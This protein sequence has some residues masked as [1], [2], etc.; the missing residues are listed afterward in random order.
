[1]EQILDDNLSTQ[2]FRYAGFWVRVGAYIIDAIILGIAQGI[3]GSMFVRTPEDMSIMTISTSTILGVL[4]FCLMESSE[5]QATV[6]KIAL[7]LKVGG[8]NGERITFMNALGRYF[9]KILSALIIFIGYI[10][11]AFDD[12]KQG[13]HDK[14][15]STIVFHTK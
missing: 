6:G 8:L 4:Y 11:V 13:L 12:K 15:A 3:I 7:N 5:K 1:M 2:Q 14:L 9:A 10:M